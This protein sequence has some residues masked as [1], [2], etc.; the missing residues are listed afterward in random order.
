MYRVQLGSPITV[1]E[2]LDRLEQSI[3]EFK[4]I[5]A[6]EE[7]RPERPKPERPEE[8]INIWKW[9]AIGTIA[10]YILRRR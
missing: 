2:F 1:E 3:R 6:R 5:W 7:A 4:R 9:I 8:G 10:L